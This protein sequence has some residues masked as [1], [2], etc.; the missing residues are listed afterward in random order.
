MMNYH[1]IY[2]KKICSACLITMVAGV[3]CE[4]YLSIKPDK[5][6]AVPSSADDLY[7]LL[8]HAPTMNYN[9]SAA[10][11]SEVGSDNLFIPT[12]T[13]H[14]IRSEENRSIYV[15]GGIPV[16]NAYWNWPYRKIAVA[17][18]VLDLIGDVHF[19]DAGQKSELIGM[20][21]FFRGYVFYEIAQVFCAFY[22]PNSTGDKP[23]IVL[24]LSSD[25]NIPSV[26]S[27]LK[28]TYNQ[29]ISDLSE[30]ARLL[31]TT[32]SRYPTRPYKASAYAAL[33]RCF[34]SVGAYDQALAY[35]DSCLMLRSELIDFNGID[36]QSSYPFERFNEEVIFYSQQGATGGMLSE[37]IARVDSMLFVSYAANDLRKSVYFKQMKDGYFAF[38]GDFSQNSNTEK[39]N[40]LTTAEMFLIRA[41]ANARKGALERAKADLDKLMKA[42]YAV[43]QSEEIDGMDQAQLVNLILDERRKELVFRGVRW[44]D[45]RR[46][47]YEGNFVITLT[48]KID[49]NVYQ[50]SPE[51]I[52]NF[53]FMIPAQ[54]I[55]RS[56]IGQNK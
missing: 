48:R 3:S 17:N 5:K 53:T 25:I 55:E 16:E 49:D 29:I 9:F 56:D 31:P 14:S 43:G 27:T 11:L 13:W 39:F 24:R 7:A 33:A 44:S 37:S 10:A 36:M 47:S 6:L 22:D 1:K 45:L 2:M 32:R 42:R 26:R 4:K 51:D 23:G 41:E 50:L 30:S 34:I 38:T 40:G 18:T 28:E 12:P 8:D 21:K 20:A 52:D 15:W 54:V 35:A 46:L 19:G